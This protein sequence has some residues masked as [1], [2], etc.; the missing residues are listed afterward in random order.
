M[1]RARTDSDPQPSREKK[2][3]EEYEE[4]EEDKLRNKGINSDSDSGELDPQPSN[5]KKTEGKHQE[6]DKSKKKRIYSDSSDSGPGPSKKRKTRKKDEEDGEEQMKK[7]RER[8]SEEQLSD[9]CCSEKKRRRKETDEGGAEPVSAQAEPSRP[10]PLSISSYN[11]YSLL[12]SGGFGKVM[13]ASLGDKKAYVAVKSIPKKEATKYNSLLTE[14]Q[15]LNIVRHIPFL[16]Q[17]YAA[18]QTQRHAF[19]VMEFLSGGSLEDQLKWHRM[20]P[21]DRVRKLMYYRRIFMALTII[22]LSKRFHSAEMI[23]GLQYLHGLGIIHRDIKPMN[24]LLDHQGHVKIVDFGVAKQSIFEDDA[25]TGW[26]GTLGYMAPEIL[27]GKAYNAAVDW[28]SF[29]VTIC[30]IA[31]GQSPFYNSDP[32]QLKDS[33]KFH[34]PKIPDWLDEDLTHLLGKL[35]QKDR[36]QRLGVRGDIRSHPFYKGIDWVALEEGELQPPYQPKT[37][38]PD[39]FQPCTEKLSF[40]EP[41]EDEATSGESNIVPG[42]S[43]QSSTWLEQDMANHKISEFCRKIQS[44][45]SR[46]FRSALLGTECCYLCC[47]WR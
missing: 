14:S 41:Q 11:F 30:E 8:S 10:N 22:S 31:T 46:R 33:I 19:Y 32:D 24:V 7:K 29:G 15:V 17:G 18:F 44:F 40:L 43:F 5:E 12:G 27:H 13:L 26:A 23:C 2:R 6:E 4:D 1:K 39:L 20:L 34:E 36:K 38:S 3:R 16:C 47:V 9:E 45:P 37:P 42:F 25:T 28:W 35:L 21:M